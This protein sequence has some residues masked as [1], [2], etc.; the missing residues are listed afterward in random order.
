VG[1]E[2]SLTLL[3]AKGQRLGFA[4]EGLRAF[5]QIQRV[6]GVPDLGLAFASK[7]LSPAQLLELR[8]SKHAQGLRDWFA[9]GAPTEGAEDIVKRYVDTVGQPSWIESLPVKV[10][11]FAT[12]AGWG[13]MEPASGTAASALDTFLL[14]KW[15]PARAPRLF[16]KQAKVVLANTPFIRPPVMK[17]R[18][19]NSP[20]SCGSGK[21]YKHCCGK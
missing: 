5:A 19:R 8:F 1:D 12:T 17:G 21:K 7:Q 16:L 14:S 18:D 2:A 13:A 9:A 6:S 11:R 10:F 4:P 20:C 3:R 15:F